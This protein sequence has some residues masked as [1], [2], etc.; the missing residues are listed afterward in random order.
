[1]KRKKKIKPK[2]VFQPKQKG[3]FITIKTSLKSILK[4]YENNYQK[5]NDI[6]LEC[7]RN[8]NLLTRTG[9]CRIQEIKT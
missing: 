7:N 1:M 5:I 2:S 3:N 9:N 4:D 6:V 8:L